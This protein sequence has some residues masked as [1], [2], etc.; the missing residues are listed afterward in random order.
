MHRVL[1]GVKCHV[2]CDISLLTSSPSRTPERLTSR[3]E[4][5]RRSVFL[6]SSRMTS[7]GLSNRRRDV[8]STLTARDKKSTPPQN[9]NRW[10]DGEK[11]TYM[12]TLWCLRYLQHM[13]F[14]VWPVR[15]R[16]DQQYMFK[17]HRQRWI[18][19]SP[20]TVRFLCFVFQA[21]FWLTFCH[22]VK[23]HVPNLILIVI[24]VVCRKLTEEK[25]A[26]YQRFG[27]RIVLLFC[28]FWVFFYY[29]LL[30]YS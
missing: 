8:S 15:E 20:H 29:I 4:T 28:E 1:F 2:W 27:S 26:T 14:F 6:I 10:A 21:G 7:V 9:T 11:R 30:N 18:S 22:V 19:F 3:W 12:N 25:T 17:S 23:V 5:V 24:S 13:N 16:T